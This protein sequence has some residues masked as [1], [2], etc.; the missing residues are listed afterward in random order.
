[1]IMTTALLAATT[2]LGAPAQ[3]EVKSLPGWE[4]P[5][6]SKIYSGFCEAS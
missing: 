5:L 2:V 3:Y 6:K 1:M 4:G